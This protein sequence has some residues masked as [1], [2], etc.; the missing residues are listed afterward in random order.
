MFFPSTVRILLLPRSSPTEF[1]PFPLIPALCLAR[2]DPKNYENLGVNEIPHLYFA[3]F[4]P[5]SMA[6]PFARRNKTL[7]DDGSDQFSQ[8]HSKMPCRFLFMSPS[9]I[10]VD[11]TRRFIALAVIESARP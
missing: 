4:P 10:P 11:H 2:L 9:L 3:V 6:L 7:F 1:R 5:I 8:F